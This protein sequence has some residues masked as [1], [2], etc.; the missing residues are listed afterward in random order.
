MLRPI[1]SL[2][3]YLQKNASE[4]FN[5]PNSDNNNQTVLTEEQQEDD[6]D[7]AMETITPDNHFR[8][9]DQSDQNEN[10]VKTDFPVDNDDLLTPNATNVSTEDSFYLDEMPT[11]LIVVDVNTSTTSI[12]NQSNDSIGDPLAIDEFEADELDDPLN[13]S[14][15]ANDFVDLT[16]SSEGLEEVPAPNS[17]STPL[18]SILKKRNDKEEQSDGSDSGLGSENSTP[19]AIIPKQQ[20]RS[21]LKRRAEDVDFVQKEKKPKRSINFDVVQVYYFP[22]RQGFNCVP[23]QGGCTLG[24]DKIHSSFKIFPLNDHYYESRP[25]NI[26]D[27]SAAATATTSASKQNHNSSGEESDSDEDFTEASESDM[28]L[29]NS[30]FLQPIPIKQRR[31]MLRAAGVRKIDPTEKKE[32]RDIRTSREYC[33]CNCRGF[34]D[35]DTCMC[36]RFGIKCQVDR[37]SFPCKCT[38]D[39]CQN[40]Q[41]RVEF[42]PERVRRHYIHTMMRLSL[43]S[44]VGTRHN[45]H[46][47]FLQQSIT[48]KD[49]HN[50]IGHHQYHHQPSS[51]TSNNFYVPDTPTH[52]TV[53]YTQ[54]ENQ[55]QLAY[56]TYY[57][58]PFNTYNIYDENA[59]QHQP[60]SYSNFNSGKGM[61]VLT[62]CDQLHDESK[63]IIGFSADGDVELNLNVPTPPGR[64]DVEEDEKIYTNLEVPRK[65]EVE[66]NDIP[67]SKV[68][69]VLE[70]VK[71]DE[72]SKE[73]G[74]SEELKD[75]VERS[76]VV[77][78]SKVES[79]EDVKKD[80][81]SEDVKDEKMGSSEDLKEGSSGD[82]M[83]LKEESAEGSKDIKEESFE[84]SKVLKEDSCEDTKNIKE[85]SLEDSKVL[86]EDSKDIQEDVCGDTKDVKEESCEDSKKES[87]EDSK[88]ESCEGSRNTKEESSKESKEMEEESSEDSKEESSENL[89]DIKEKSSEESKEMKE[90]SSEDL[91]EE[92]S[93]NSK[94]IKEESSENS[95]EESSENVKDSKAESCDDVKDTKGENYKDSL[96][97]ENTILENKI[98]EEGKDNVLEVKNNEDKSKE[99]ATSEKSFSGETSENK[100]D[101]SSENKVEPT[102]QLSSEDAKDSIIED[103]VKADESFESCTVEEDTAILA[104]EEKSVTEEKVDEI[105]QTPKSVDDPKNVTEEKLDEIKQTPKS[106]EDPV[107]I[108]SKI[109]ETTLN[110]DETEMKM[111]VQEDELEETTSKSE[112]EVD[113]KPESS[114]EIKDK[115]E[116]MEIEETAPGVECPKDDQNSFKEEQL[117]VEEPVKEKE[118]VAE[119][120]LDSPKEEVQKEE[121]KAT[122]TPK[123]ENQTSSE[124]LQENGHIVTSEEMSDPDVPPEEE[125]KDAVDL[126][127][128]SMEVDEDFQDAVEHPA[129]PTEVLHQNG[130]ELKKEELPT[131]EEPLKENGQPLIVGQV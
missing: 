4:A 17:P 8:T 103:E 85:E 83:D 9:L 125:F 59:H 89:K 77:K 50:G 45:P 109:Q 68:G 75:L 47:Y 67:D 84:D 79:F 107:E 28:D 7:I 34:C 118:D 19:S 52:S 48:E 12:L 90:E 98:S 71:G 106:V 38:H 61:E 11:E 14:G 96:C 35:P 51:S 110:S 114:V 131:E 13:S 40:P 124:D 91:K 81:S 126:K 58:S 111:E 6:D 18:Q 44:T 69:S 101:C 121:P 130:G 82:V 74:S 129:K 30:G 104:T 64:E 108:P 36:S 127:D 42:N 128:S 76:G 31:V 97:E 10:T 24:M 105:K 15:N 22:R 87:C 123:L 20:L 16:N 41:G 116:P 53:S 73:E 27:G 37:P 3:T 115:P 55:A 57:Q 92:S 33:G 62:R 63:D 80:G 78:D 23:S 25:I 95:K 26:Q 94:D 112:V 113:P 56:N 70:D 120:K 43:E 99:E 122:D 1:K 86:K 93:E 21:N 46:N 88:E 54:N 49:H 72:K 39:T 119:D 32:C 2:L 60:S 5:S 66:G 29:D 102:D 100:E 65:G 117:K